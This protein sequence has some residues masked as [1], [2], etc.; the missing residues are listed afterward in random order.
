MSRLAY[1]AIA[2]V[3]AS[4]TMTTAM[5]RLHRNLPDDE[6]YA[7]PPRE[8]IHGI[9]H[10]RGGLADPRQDEDASSS[11]TM[12]AH[13]AYGGLT[14]ALFGLQRDR[15]VITGVG[16]GLGVWAASYLGWIPAARILTPA[17]RHPMRRNAMMLAAHAVWG[18]I[19]A[20]GMREIE[21]AERGAFRHRGKAL[22][23][24][25]S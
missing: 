7:V 24:V 21:A 14:G 11:W 10:D 1:G 3:A 17:T 22:Q 25:K 2:G 9:S 13:F 23:D 5:R 15:G 19:L 12:L 16:Y 18:A 8:I 20:L 4:L 6:Q